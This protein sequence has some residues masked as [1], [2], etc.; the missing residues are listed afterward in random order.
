MNMDNSIAMLLQ[1]HDH[2]LSFDLSSCLPKDLVIEILSL[3]PVKSLLRFC[4]VSDSWNF[5][6]ISSD[7][8]VKKHL[9]RSATDPN[10]RHHHLLVEV[11]RNDFSGDVYCL[12]NSP[13]S[14]VDNPPPPSRS[15][16]MILCDHPSIELPRGAR[17]VGSCNGLICWVSNGNGSDNYVYCLNPSTGVECMSPAF[18]RGPLN[19][20]MLGFGYDSVSDSY[21]I[22][23]ISKTMA[24]VYTLGS[25]AEN[26]RKME[27]SVPFLPMQCNQRDYGGRF[28]SGALNWLA[29]RPD[30]TPVV[31]YVDIGD[32]I[33]GEFSLP[34]VIDKNSLYG[35]PSLWVLGG[36][37]CFSYEIGNSEFVLWQM[38]EYGV[39][40]SWT[41]LLKLSHGDLR[42]VALSEY[43]PRPLFMFDNGEVLLRINKSGAFVLYNPRE[44]SFKN[45]NLQ[46]NVIWYQASPHIESLVSPC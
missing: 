31:V 15:P 18:R 43:F 35:S 8:F 14:L 7:D 9:R 39:A 29:L 5:L 22:V 33:G 6:I 23:L 26:W 36:Y 10:H 46:S 42:T 17:I 21:K 30:G 11:K 37:L 45:I 44:K 2:A 34:S 20:T 24:G 27:Q 3:L 19:S 13:Q 28:V 4:H 32:E 12:S 40:E 16:S 41:M 1:D 38:K 25:G